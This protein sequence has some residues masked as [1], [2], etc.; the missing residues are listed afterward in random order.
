VS[1]L[2]ANGDFA[3]LNLFAYCGNNPIDRKDDTGGFWHIVAGAAI[4]GLIGAVSS[5]V[6]QVVS[7]NEINWGEVAVSAGAGALS[8]AINAACPG[9]GAV[10]TGVIQGAIGAG[11]YA[12]TELVNGRTPTV[13]GTLAAGITSGVLAGGTKA[14]SNKIAQNV[15]PKSVQNAGTPFK[16]VGSS[17]IGVDPNT[18]TLNPNFTPHQGKYNSA[19]SRI[20]SEGMYGVIEVYRNGMVINGQHRVLIGRLLGLAVDVIIR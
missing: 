14:V 1:L 10:A 18:L 20:K 8:G 4:G 2:G 7:G 9:M 6:G 11:T 17:Q 13:G 5:I 3:S 12:A 16:G 15:C 19:L